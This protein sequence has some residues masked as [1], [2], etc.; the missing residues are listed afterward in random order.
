MSH[1]Q[2]I[3]TMEEQDILVSPFMHYWDLCEL[4]RYFTKH[5]AGVTPP[6]RAL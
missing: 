4:V 1:A 2:L 6:L 3:A 5:M